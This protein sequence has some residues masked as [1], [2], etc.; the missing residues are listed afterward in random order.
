MKRLL[1]VLLVCVCV[2]P[3]VRAQ[4]PAPRDLWPQAAAAADTGDIDSAIKKTN[5]L[6]DTGKGYG[7]RRYPLYAD[8]AA[9]LARQADKLKDKPRADWASKAADQLDPR[10]STVA[11][12]KADRAA[13]Q[14]QFGQ[15]VPA[16]MKG[17]AR[18]FNGYRS[19][20]L[21]RCDLVIVIVV[22]FVLSAV[23]FA[24]SLFVRYG[25]SMAHDFREMLSARLRGGA[26]TVLAFALLFLPIFLWL[27]PFWLIFY[28]FIIFF[29]YANALER[30]AILVFALA[31]AAA[32]IVLDLT[33][34]WIAGVD[35]PVVQSAIAGEEQSYNPGALHRLEELVGIVPD[36]ATL[37]LLL[38]N[39]R[40]QEGNEAGAATAYR[41]S[42]ELADSAGGHV[43]LGNLHFADNDF[44]AAI[45]E[46]EKAE[47]L[48]PKLAI[49][50][51]NHSVASGELYKFEDQKAELEQAKRLEK[52]YIEKV[53]SNPD[54]KE[55]RVIN[56]RPPIPAAWT[57]AANI[58]RR[59]A[60]QS[61][62]GNYS[63][64]DPA[65]SARNPYTIG[66]VMA[67]IL[68]P[69]FWFRRRREGYAGMCIKCGRT[70]CYRCK[71]ARESATYCTQCI[72]IYLKRDGVS[73]AT[74][75]EKLD[76][77][78]DHQTGMLRRNKIF[79]TFL[80]GSAQLLEGRTLVG[81]L[82]LLAFVFLV[83]LAVSVGR[84]A[85]VVTGDL[86]KMMVRA[87]AVLLA[88]VVWFSMTLPVY[89]RRAVIT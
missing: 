26:V 38:G 72:H 20:L 78:H 87:L 17:F 34:H 28:W 56:Y 47:Q 40:L 46:Y 9:G 54:P 5:E 89:K 18:V 57:V 13:Q 45:T 23:I 8:S 53:S 77:V 32:P 30:V 64:F 67:F 6:I 69:F 70:F 11:F 73:L 24:V 37:Q 49:A 79:A 66:G 82:G 65:I 55:P 1:P 86:A 44:G 74:K 14:K 25:R 33:A 52:S 60:A 31:I 58:A 75:R 21:S 19:S 50:F 12:N 7:I 36:N 68:A 16:A 10:S 41:R 29:G 43:N 39:L 63:W 88:L 4:Q 80:P 61:L 85:P 62:F 2:A 48:D 42:L 81:L 15:A 76:E 27:G 51:Y 71:S 3:L 22:A 84:L 83:C 35:S 59:G